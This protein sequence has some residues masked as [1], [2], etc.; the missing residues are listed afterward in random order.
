[1]SRNKK[2]KKLPREREIF[3]RHHQ[4]HFV[5]S[6]VVFTLAKLAEAE[7]LAASAN[8]FKK[9]YKR[10]FSF[11]SRKKRNYFSFSSS[12]VLVVSLNVW[13]TTHCCN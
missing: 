3:P 11:V 4:P 13:L 2:K 7:S 9:N 10:S 5:I 6:L 1:M 12:F 8:G